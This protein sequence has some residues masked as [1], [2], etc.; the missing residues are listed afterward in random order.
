MNKKYFIAG[1]FLLAFALP[2][3]AHPGIGLVQDSKGNIY[4]TDLKQVWKR[5]PDGQLSIAVPKVQTHQLYMDAK[6]NLYG[7]NLEYEGDTK[8]FSHYLWVLHPD[9]K[10]ET[11]IGPKQA[12][13]THDYSLVRDSIGDQYWVEQARLSRFM[14]ETPDGVVTQL[15][16]G[17]FNNLKWMYATPEGTLYFINANALYKID[18]THLI[19]PVAKSLPVTTDSF[20][21]AS[22]NNDLMGIWSDYSGNI[23]VAVF[24]GQLIKKISPKGAV[25]IVENS[26][27]GWSPTAGLFDKK[28]DLWIMEYNNRNE[29]RVR[30]IENFT[31]HPKGSSTKQKVILTIAIFLGLVSAIAI[32][33]FSTRSRH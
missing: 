9:G 18:S 10:L 12:F 7:E 2:L 31:G 20:A 32:L 5:S 3:W 26:Q 30:K 15:A 25:T 14:K 27:D 29:V 1:I 33:R 17:F 23:Y 16:E 11:L 13:V 28:G 21:F 19:R 6:D 4:Y 22:P 8:K 24:S